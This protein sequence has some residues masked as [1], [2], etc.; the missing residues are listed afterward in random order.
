MNFPLQRFS[1]Y[2]LFI[3]AIFSLGALEFHNRADPFGAGTGLILL[4]DLNCAADARSL[5]DCT[6]RAWGSNNCGHNEDVGVSCSTGDTQIVEQVPITI[7]TT[8]TMTSA[9]PT[10]TTQAPVEEH[11][12]Y[13]WRL[14]GER[15]TASSGRVEVRQSGG[16]WGTVCDD[17]VGMDE[18]NMICIAL[19][20]E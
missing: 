10:R 4:D 9:A 15:A 17:L 19:G 20:F 14:A 16:E 8:Q 3:F 11:I 1:L 7:P 12:T 18:A 5:V 2:Y 6:H 13:E